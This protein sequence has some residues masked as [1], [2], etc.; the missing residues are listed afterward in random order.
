ML[1]LFDMEERADA[2]K[3]EMDTILAEMAAGLEG[4][5]DRV[6]ELSKKLTKLSL[7]AKILQ[8]NLVVFR[9][10]AEKLVSGPCSGPH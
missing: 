10:L 1:T 2:I 3:A 4:Q 5:E 6:V 7:E 9:H 8:N